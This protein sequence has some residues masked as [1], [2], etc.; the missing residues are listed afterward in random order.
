M[1]TATLERPTV[2]AEPVAELVTITPDLAQLWL[3]LNTDNRALKTGQIE[4]YARDLAEGRWWVNGDTV[5]FAGPRHMPTKLLDGQN[6]LHA[7]LKS[8]VPLRTFVVFG[9]D[10]G[11]QP[12]MDSGAKRT[13]ADNL[14]IAGVQYASDVAAA[15]ALAIRFQ[16]G[17]VAGYGSVVSNDRA[18][19]FIAEHPDLVRSASVAVSTTKKAG[20]PKSYITYTHW[21][22]SQLDLEA[23]TVFW[24]DVAEKVGLEAGDPVLALYN[25]FAQARNSHERVSPGAAISGIF[26]AW[27][28]RRLG[29]PLARVQFNTPTGDLPKIR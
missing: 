22:F 1:S 8:G 18:V 12:S 5:V 2:T 11:A 10:E 25:R 15:A 7:V 4:A 6:R 9:V 16:D 28:A 13:V 14:R 21:R 26:R 19:E 27:N 24:R 3:G 20:V 23:A 29:Q 17:R